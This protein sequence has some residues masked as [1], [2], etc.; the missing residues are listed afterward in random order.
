MPGNWT[1]KRGV[2]DPSKLAT[3]V[4]WNNKIYLPQW[5][6]DSVCSQLR[7]TD[8][9]QFPTLLSESS[10]INIF[11]PDLC[12]DLKF[13]YSGSSEISGVNALRFDLN[14][15]YDS[16]KDSDN[17]YCTKD[18][19]TDCYKKGLMDI[20]RCRLDSHIVV[21]QPHF[22]DVDDEVIKSAK[23]NVSAPVRDVH[24]SSLHLEPFT[25][26]P[27]SVSVKLQINF[28]LQTYHLFDINKTTYEY[29]KQVVPILWFEQ[30]AQIDGASVDQLNSL[31]FSKIK[32]LRGIAGTTLA[33]GV[34]IPLVAFVIKRYRANRHIV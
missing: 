28:E 32:L 18:K 29:K 9:Q 4:N 33:L 34:V 22:L 24:S 1:I 20:A 12:R 5:K 7:G 25:G 13:S 2:N 16:E 26:V 23:N 31:L 3:L 10:D 21:S 6:N 30:S 17:C 14:Q 15:L 19:V 8:G 11:V 27:L